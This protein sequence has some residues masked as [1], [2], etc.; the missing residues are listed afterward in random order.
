MPIPHHMTYNII[1]AFSESPLHLPVMSNFEQVCNQLNQRIRIGKDK[2]VAINVS[3]KGT[4]F[5]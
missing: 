3:K 1:F 5:I 2:S 4:H